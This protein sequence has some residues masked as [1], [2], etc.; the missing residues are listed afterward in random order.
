MARRLIRSERLPDRRR[1]LVLLARIPPEIAV[2]LLVAA[3]RDPHPLANA[4][5]AESLGKLRAREALD[6]LLDALA[7]SIGNHYLSTALW[8][9]VEAITGESTGF[10]FSEPEETQRERIA[11][12]KKRVTSNE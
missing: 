5:A 2:P 3:L 7:G 1:G 12:W 10:D 9:A 6:P 8:E 4:S 11:R